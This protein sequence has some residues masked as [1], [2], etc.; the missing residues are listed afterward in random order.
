M[1]YILILTIALFLSCS[2]EDDQ[3]KFYSLVTESSFNSA[4]D[5]CSGLANSHPQMKVIESKQIGCLTQSELIEAKKAEST[6]T[7][8]L[9]FGVTYQIK[10]SV[11]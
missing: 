11:K 8:T 6:I 1:K 10:V 3:C 7:K 4:N 9:C 2:K 5:K